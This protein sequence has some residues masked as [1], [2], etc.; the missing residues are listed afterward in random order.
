MFPRDPLLRCVLGPAAASVV[1]ELMSQSL[2]LPICKMGLISPHMVLTDAKVRSPLQETQSLGVAC[3]SRRVVSCHPILSCVSCA[4]KSP[5]NV[6]F[7]RSW[8]CHCHLSIAFSGLIALRVGLFPP[9]AGRRNQNRWCVI[10]DLKLLRDPGGCI[11]CF[12]GHLSHFQFYRIN[13]LAQTPEETQ[14]LSL[15]LFQGPRGEGE[16]WTVAGRAQISR[17]FFLCPSPPPALR[18]C[19]ETWHPGVSLGWVWTRLAHLSLR[20][21]R[22]WLIRTSCVAG[23]F[24]PA[25]PLP[26]L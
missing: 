11:P 6:P 15:C 16:G 8:V 17:L 26:L 4:P 19:H 22:I 10:R 3:S 21:G 14:G 25:P 18:P 24:H 2:S 13:L 20:G 7:R 9:K 12:P 5:P 1:L 23:G